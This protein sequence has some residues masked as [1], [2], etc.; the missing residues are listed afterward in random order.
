M[1]IVK[2]CLFSGKTLFLDQING[3][4][5]FLA[6]L[7]FIG[8]LACSDD[9]SPSKTQLLTNGSFKAWFISTAPNSDCEGIENMSNDNTW[10]FFN[11]GKF[12]FDR[13]TVTEAGDC[14]DIKNVTGTWKF[15]EN[16]TKIRIHVSY[17]TDD[18]SDIIDQEL[19]FASIVELAADKMVLDMDGSAATFNPR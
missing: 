2:S 3:M 19:V 16:E 14:S 15:E 6:P 5:I 7:V 18:S 13:G 10:T 1:D 11:D 4:K 9:E 8:L 17:N 12:T